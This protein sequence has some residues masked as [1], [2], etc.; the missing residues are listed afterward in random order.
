MKTFIY[1]ARD[2]GGNLVKGNMEAASQKDVARALN[3]ENLIAVQISEYK[4]RRLKKKKKKSV[5]L[6]G[7]VKDKD[8]AVF[9]RQLSTMI[10][11]GVSVAE[12][13]EDLSHT[14]DNPKLRKAL[15]KILESVRSGSS[16]SD[17]FAQYPQFFSNLFVH[18]TR[19]GEESGNLGLVLRDMSEYL[20]KKVKLAGQLRSASMY[21]MFV[22]GFFL[23]I[24]TAL[25][26]FLIPQFTQLFASLGAELPLP[27]RIV[28]RISEILVR[29]APLLFISLVLLGFGVSIFYKTLPGRFIIDSL[30][31][32]VPIFG[33]LYLKISLARFFQTLATL[34][35]SG[36]D[37]VS[38]LDI[39]S[40]V[41][42]NAVIEGKAKK[43]RKG[44]IEG[45][46]FS[47]ELKKGRLFPPITVSMTA[48]GEKSGSIDR[49]LLKVSDYFTDEVDTEVEGLSSLL[50]PVLIISL[51]LVVGIFVVT[52]YLPIFQMAGALMGGY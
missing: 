42:N 26:L 38:S 40:K 23:L 6:T 13:L 25:V 22:A 27:T 24:I 10:T 41:V 30:K 9:C 17:G 31:L 28:M 21:P 44:V 29:N 47:E 20:E 33:N 46:S 52:M 1:K 11:S 37:V 35:K 18:M 5:A 45:S 8:I 19:A 15:A 3:E 34:L 51:G 36:V 39:A 32:R 48:V 49:M 14:L 2:P 12:S 16:L 43:I 7:R 4:G 50:E